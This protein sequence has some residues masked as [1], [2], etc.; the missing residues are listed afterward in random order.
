MAW[1]GGEDQHSDEAELAL[2]NGDGLP[3]LESGEEDYE[4]GAVDTGK[5]IGFAVIVLV[6]LAVGVGGFWWYTNRAN[7][8]AH[9]ADGS[10]VEAPEGPYKEKPEDAGGKTFAGTGNIAP[11]VAEGE[12]REVLL[13]QEAAP[14]PSIAT[15]SSDDM[16]VEQD[17]VGVQV[18]AYGSRARA[19][20]GWVTLRN[21]TT[22]L[23]GVRHRVIKGQADIGTVYR[24][25]AV[26]GDIAAARSLC[27]ALKADG[28]ACQVKR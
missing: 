3:W 14:T 6:I 15:R 22:V 7:S 27:D 28:L 1:P 20:A 25:Q 2:D 16:P 13:A 8:V 11:V 5:I 21:Q 10:T 24:L 9:V 17:G 4:E 26:A 18:G 12:Q 23:N 19:E